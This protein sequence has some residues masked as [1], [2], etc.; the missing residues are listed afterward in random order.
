MKRKIRISFL[1]LILLGLVVLYLVSHYT[2]EP[3]KSEFDKVYDAAIEFRRR[4]HEFRR[5]ESIPPMP[6]Y[7][8]FRDNFYR[9]QASKN[10]LEGNPIS[11]VAAY[12]VVI[13]YKPDSAS[14]YLGRGLAR[15]EREHYDLA[16][17]DLRMARKLD[18]NDPELSAQETIMLDTY[19]S[20]YPGK[21]PKVVD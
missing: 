20:S 14:A 5:S 21:R 7:E 4:G 13:H 15:W 1:S 19:I 11:A 6:A 9:L 2:E 18:R 17:F 3:K 10:M 12:N 16:L 8:E